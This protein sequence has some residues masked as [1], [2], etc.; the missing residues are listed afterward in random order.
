MKIHT[1]FSV[2]H[3]IFCLCNEKKGIKL[4][5]GQSLEGKY[6]NKKTDASS[7]DF[8]G[9]PIGF[10][11]DSNVVFNWK[12][13]WGF[14]F[15]SFNILNQQIAYKSNIINSN[16]TLIPEISVKFSITMVHVLA[17]LAILS[18]NAYDLICLDTQNL[19]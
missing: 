14:S 4:H 7:T 11:F 10:W 1:F 16:T 5:C 6:W 8:I 18:H 17:I 3:T 12:T 9:K 13:I 15:S 19:K 2:S